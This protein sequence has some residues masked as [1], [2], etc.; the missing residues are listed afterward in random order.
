[1]AQGTIQPGAYTYTNPLAAMPHAENVTA[2]ALQKWAAQHEVRFELA[3]AHVK[4]L[5][6]ARWEGGAPMAGW[7]G[8]NPKRPFGDMTYFELDMADILGE[9]V[10]RDAEGHLPAQQAARL[11][12]LY[13][14][15]QAA[16]QVFLQQAQVGPGTYP[17]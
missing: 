13:G 4:L 17:R 1:M 9:P 11:G 10:V 12:I 8:L 14:E 5:K 7:L 6:H 16:L 15:M 2:P 3:A